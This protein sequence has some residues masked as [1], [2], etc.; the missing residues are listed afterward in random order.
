WRAIASAAVTTISVAGLSLAAFGASPWAEFPRELVAQADLNLFATSDR[1]GLSQ[2]IYGLVRYLD[3][4]A[5]IA[6][7]AQ[8]TTTLIV[9]VVVWLVWRSQ[10]RYALKA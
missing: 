6:W 1:W 4:I 9:G 3:G 5:A 7:M 8:G 10:V 2:S